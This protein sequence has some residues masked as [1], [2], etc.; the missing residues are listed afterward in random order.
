MPGAALFRFVIRV[1]IILVVFAYRFVSNRYLRQIVA[2]VEEEVLDLVLRRGQVLF[3]VLLVP[4]IE[5]WLGNLNLG[6]EIFALKG[7]KANFNFL[8]GIIEPV[9]YFILGHGGK[10]TD[11]LDHPADEQLFHNSLFKGGGSQVI[12]FQNCLVAVEVKMAVL[13]KHPHSLDFFLNGL[14]ADLDSELCCSLAKQF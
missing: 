11:G 1:D 6:Y 12:A 7:S 9:F 10:R 4:G 3:F 8:I 13:V 5:F 14:L 2:V